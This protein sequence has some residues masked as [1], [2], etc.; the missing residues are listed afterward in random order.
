[1]RTLGIIFASIVAFIALLIGGA[2][3][4]WKINYPTYS[5]RY[6]LTLA[7]EIDGKVHAGSSVIEIVWG[8]GPEIGDVG[9][10]HPSIRGQAPLVDLG[11]HG[12]V[13]ATLINSDYGRAADGTYSVIWIA[14]RAFG[15]DSTNQELPKLPHLTGL[16]HLSP[17]NMP[18]LVWFS[19]I[20][21]P[22][23]A[24][25]ITPADIPELFGPNARL[26]NAT[27]EIT[28]DPIV[29]DIN[30]KLPWYKNKK[31]PWYKDLR[32]P[33]NHGVMYLP[34]GFALADTMFIGG[35]SRDK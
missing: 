22:S 9:H 1:M 32:E 10:Y 34:G 18:Q 31:L 3:V 20:S 21:D 25:K 6:R 33:R 15:N 4:W 17:D 8:G 24:R 5:Y 28:S 7:I 11:P 16:R 14:A 29:I 13:I 27:V 23:T 2:I 30:K 19:N 12:A 35:G 26:S